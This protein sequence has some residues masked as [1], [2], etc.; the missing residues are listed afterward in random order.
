M[1]QTVVKRNGILNEDDILESKTELIKE[2]VTKR[3][4]EFV[5]KA[6]WKPWANVLGVLALS[7]LLFL[8][9]LFI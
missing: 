9:S 6:V 4:N 8:A 1:S 7:G 3:K 5:N 2:N